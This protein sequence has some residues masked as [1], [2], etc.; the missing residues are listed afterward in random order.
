MSSLKQSPR[1]IDSLHTLNVWTPYALL[2]RRL[3]ETYHREQNPF[4]AAKFYTWREG[5]LTSW[6]DTEIISS[7]KTSLSLPGTLP[8]SVKAGTGG[9]LTQPAV[10][11]ATPV[12]R[13]PNYWILVF[14][15][16]LTSD[17][18]SV[19]VTFVA[20]Y[21]C[22]SGRGFGHL[23]EKEMNQIWCG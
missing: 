5:E 7:L 6:T 4:A 23:P 22:E 21:D 12:E 14:K 20:F 13:Y 18:L 2:M 19:P 8:L 1:F 16:F 11:S 17:D 3:Y 9:V 10:V 15:G